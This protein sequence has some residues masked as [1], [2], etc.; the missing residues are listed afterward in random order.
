MKGQDPKQA[1]KNLFIG[2]SNAF[3]KVLMKLGITTAI[4]ATGGYWVSTTGLAPEVVNH[5]GAKVNSKVGGMD[6]RLVFETLVKSQAERYA[7]ADEWIKNTGKKEEKEEGAYATELR[8]LFNLVAFPYINELKKKVSANEC[9]EL[10]KDRQ[11]SNEEISDIAFGMACKWREKKNLTLRDNLRVKYKYRDN[12]ITDEMMKNAPS[13]EQIF[14]HI[15]QSHMSLGAQLRP[16]P[17]IILI[18]YCPAFWFR[19]CCLAR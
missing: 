7:G 1:M 2:E 17:V 6:M 10:H 14:K 12:E 3:V 13:L 8:E 16:A 11:F 18:I 5:G 15:F 9:P 4:G 19:P